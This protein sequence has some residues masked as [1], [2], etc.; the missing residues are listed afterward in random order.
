MEQEVDSNNR[1]IQH[2][3]EAKEQKDAEI[4]RAH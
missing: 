2:L 3:G 1:R 4:Q